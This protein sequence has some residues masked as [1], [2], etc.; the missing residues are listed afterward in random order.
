MVT[1]RLTHL[2]HAGPWAT[3]TALTFECSSHFTDEQGE[4]QRDERV[5]PRCL[6]GGGA[7]P[8][9]YSTPEFESQP[10]ATG[11]NR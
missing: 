10:H 5:G 4:A 9:S 3:R 6:K 11:R 2:L 7:E 8:N 1:M